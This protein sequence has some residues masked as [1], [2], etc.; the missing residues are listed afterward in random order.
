MNKSDDE[1][2]VP[3]GEYIDALNVRLG[4]TEQSEIG[5]VEKTK[6]NSL[7]GDV[8]FLG[9]SLSA[10]AKCIGAFADERSETLYWFINDPSNGD[11]IVSYNTTGQSLV[12][13]LITINLLNFNPKYL[14]NSVNLIGDLLFWTDNLNPPRKI[15]INR[16]YDLPSGGSD[17]LTEDD[18]SVIVKP[19]SSSPF[20][21]F[22]N[23]PPVEEGFLFENL[24]CFGYRFKYR[25][26]EW[27]AISQFSDPAFIPQE[28]FNYNYSTTL[29]DGMTNIYNS[30]NVEFSTGSS[31]VTDIQLI[32]KNSSDDVL[33][34]VDTYNK[35]QLGWSDNI[36]QDVFFKNKEILTVLS[37]DEI[38]RIFDNVPRLA[39]AQTFMSNRLMYG[40]YVDGYDLIDV[41]DNKLNI[42]FSCVLQALNISES[43][44]SYHYGGTSYNTISGRYDIAGT[45]SNASYVVDT[46][47]PTTIT[48][49]NAIQEFD[50][51][52]IELNQGSIIVFRGSFSPNATSGQF[53]NENPA[54]LNINPSNRG[55]GYTATTSFVNITISFFLTESYATPYAFFNSTDF[56][57]AF[58]IGDASSSPTYFNVFS[59]AAGANSGTA[60]TTLTDILNSAILTYPALN[61]VTSANAAAVN[62]AVPDANNARYNPAYPS[63]PTGQTG[64][65]LTTFAP[66]SLDANILKLQAPMGVYYS[67]PGSAGGVYSY[68]SYQFN[69]AGFNIG[70]GQSKKSLHS[71]RDYD[72]GLVYMD[73]YNRSTT[74]LISQDNSVNVPASSS[75]NINVIQTTIPPDLLPPTWAKKFKFV[76]K[77]SALDYDTIYSA[78]V[79]SSTESSSTSFWLLL[80]GE[81]STKVAVGQKLILKSDVNGPLDKF[82]E[83]TV[84]EKTN[85]PS[86]SGTAG[87][88]FPIGVYIKLS[89]SVDYELKLDSAISTASDSSSST[90]SGSALL[91]DKYAN[92]VTILTNLKSTFNTSGPINEGTS[93]RIRITLSR[94]TSSPL[95]SGDCDKPG[96]TQL[97]ITRSASQTYSTG[98]L[99]DQLASMIEND[100]TDSLGFFPTSSIS[101][102]GSLIDDIPI[103]FDNSVAITDS[104]FAQPDGSLNPPDGPEYHL[105]SLNSNNQN[106]AGT[107]VQGLGVQSAYYACASFTDSGPSIISTDIS[108]SSALLEDEI[109]ILETQPTEANPDFFYENSSCYDIT[110]G[111]H[112]G[113][114]Q[115][116]FDWSFYDNFQN[117]AYRS[118]VGLASTS[119]YGGNVAFSS[120]TAVGGNGQT[121]SYSLG[122]TVYINQSN[123]SP[124]NPQYNGVHIVRQIPD[125][126]TIVIDVAFGSSTPVSGGTGNSP[127][128]ILNDFFNC[129]SFG[130][131]TESMSILDSITE[132]KLSIGNRIYAVA[133]QEYE[134]TR[135]FSSITYSGRF[136]EQSNINRLNQFNLGSLNFKDLNQRFGDI[137]IIDGRKN[138]VLVLQEDKISYVLAGKDQLTQADGSINLTSVSAVLGTQIPRIENFGISNNPESFVKYGKDKFFTDS[139]RGAVLQIS[140]SGYSDEALVSVSD[141]GMRSWFRDL[142]I[143]YPNTQKLGGF[144]PYMDEYVLSSNTTALPLDNTKYECGNTISLSNEVSDFNYTVN[145]GRSIGNATFTYNISLGTIKIHVTYNGV[146]TSSG[147]LTGSGTFVLNKNYASKI[148]SSVRIEVISPSTPASYSITNGCVVSNQ[149]NVV[150]VTVNNPLGEGQTIN[151]EFQWQNTEPY[152]SALYNKNIVFPV[153]RLSTG[154]AGDFV[155]Q[156]EVISGNEGNGMIP[157]TDYAVTGAKDSEITVKC[158]KKPNNTFTFNTSGNKL[159]FLITN[160]LYSNT[161]S[162]INSLISAA[163]DMTITTTTLNNN[164]INQG[165]FSFAP[166]TANYDYI[167][168]I[169]NYF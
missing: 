113:N 70:E 62:S 72:I 168:I 89:S 66:P 110:G 42:N 11:L 97:D 91:E 56:K 15:N 155:S 13:H 60:G 84:L 10:Y 81:Q 93:I 153:S 50:F 107:A 73:E 8:N 119:S 3:Q 27:S 165:S 151:N 117:N 9:S 138:D 57:R 19:P 28:N 46:T 146:T 96:Y 85:T 52:G 36:T 164:V 163:T 147:N 65:A 169:Y 162:D 18:I 21:V 24:I 116:Q 87:T 143:E 67:T 55:N 131:G 158:V 83:V 7:V 48:G 167:Y 38:L 127:C 54:L 61:S 37:S 154:T 120:N 30:V 68:E 104:N 20:V 125:A 128:V 59:D 44:E 82:T 64:F 106:P 111:K 100:M 94:S 92:C 152:T 159:Q 95:P 129:F 4:S 149:I 103:K 77:P 43:L 26:E 140:G 5:S 51:T 74:A 25:D 137:E 134:E 47:T 109:I 40:N 101:Y 161:T 80:E 135:R 78:F 35:E 79:K 76:I 2:L 122:D 102:A 166:T 99:A 108:M 58:G 86:I 142:F 31:L 39:S 98:T 123:L 112:L 157:T 115:N 16:T 136:N 105:I 45:P 41:N 124:V 23:T 14:I 118:T 69:L 34:V 126:F 133:E 49:F 53:Y 156:Y 32:F 148:K 145:Y 141:L 130:Q 88:D 121:H 75:K 114:L 6:G 144:D 17:V 12:Y 132:P 22:S 90:Q 29:N 33:K 63:Y 160:T 139:K 1:R 150:L 71:S